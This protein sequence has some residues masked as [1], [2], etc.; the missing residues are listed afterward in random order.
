MSYEGF[1]VP[2]LVKHRLLYHMDLNYRPK[3][4]VSLDMDKKLNF[5]V[6]A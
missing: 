1:A 4:R 2:F 3:S 6:T 5:R